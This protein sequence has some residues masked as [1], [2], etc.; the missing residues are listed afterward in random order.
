LSAARTS[1]AGESIR[2]EGAGRISAR[3][4]VAGG[5]PAGVLLG[6]LLARAG[7]DT[8][9]LEKHGDF[10]RDFRGDTIH[11]STL[12]NIYELGLLDAF[13]EVPHQ[14]MEQIGAE[15]GGKFVWI[16]DCTHL[17]THCKYVALMPQWDFLNFF[18][19]TGA[20]LPTFHLRMQTDARELIQDGERIVG[21]RAQTPAGPM[22]VYADLVV[23]A[24][25]RHSVLRER[26]GLEA[27]SF[28]VPI[29]VLWMKIS[30]REG[31]P[32]QTLGRADRGVILVMIDRQT[33]FQCAFVIKKGGFEQIKQRGI[34]AFRQDV[35]RV[36]PFVRDRLDEISSWDMVSLLTVR[37]D[38][39]VR[40]Y[41]PGLLFIGDAAHAMSPIGGVGINLAIQDAVAAA[42]ALV[43]AMQQ[44]KPGIETLARIQRR[45][46]YPTR[47]TQRL[48][49]FIQ[50]NIISRVV[51]A[52]VKLSPPWPMRL[53]NRVALLRRIPARIIGIGFRPEHIR[54]P[55]AVN[56]AQ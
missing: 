14:V 51:E 40:W 3:C 17:P 42:N 15:V 19:R 50:D 25:G 38:R 24:D 26:A 46:E 32:G 10:F 41:R 47:M 45:R 28:G 6:Y 30:K 7:I 18:A 8:V 49:V 13:L 35:A 5:G 44:G 20:R 56:R 27:K 53:L 22:E 34:E 55:Q 16:A 37:V 36:A 39:L 23:G 2:T 4:C 54:T 48:Q 21:V 52:D 43:P 1:A 31:D 9:V 33:Y 29:D 12:E 11:P